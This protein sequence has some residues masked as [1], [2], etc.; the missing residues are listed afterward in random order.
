MLRIPENR[1]FPKNQADRQRLDQKEQA[2]MDSF[3]ERMRKDL[4]KV[5]IQEIEPALGIEVF[6]ISQKASEFSDMPY[7]KVSTVGDAGCGPL[8][9][10]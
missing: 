2:E 5:D 9:M 6:P 1:F 3:Q 10:E 7:G 8:A 4:S